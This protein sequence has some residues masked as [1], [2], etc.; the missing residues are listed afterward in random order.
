MPPAFHHRSA[1][2]VAFDR[3]EGERDSKCFYT[4]ISPQPAARM[5]SPSPAATWNANTRP[6]TTTHATSGAVPAARETGRSPVDNPDARQRGEVSARL[7]GGLPPSRTDGSPTTAAR[8]DPASICGTGD[9]SDPQEVIDALRPLH[10]GVTI[11]ITPGT[12]KR[13]PGRVLS[14]HFR[15]TISCPMAGIEVPHHWP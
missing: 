1:V 8:T 9:S 6:L 4:F 14:D 10:I 13:L 5:A 7:R 12:A 15:L 11:P 2:R 3:V